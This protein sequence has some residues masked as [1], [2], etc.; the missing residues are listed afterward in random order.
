MPLA[1]YTLVLVGPDVSALRSATLPVRSKVNSDQILIWSDRVD[2]NI[3]EEEARALGVE[4]DAIQEAYHPIRHCEFCD[5]GWPD[6][7]NLLRGYT[8]LQSEILEVQSGF[9]LDREIWF[10]NEKCQLLD[11]AVTLDN[12]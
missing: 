10:C 2:F 9:S 1:K 3:P 4:E 11:F 12:S 6:D 7:A 8:P 5:K